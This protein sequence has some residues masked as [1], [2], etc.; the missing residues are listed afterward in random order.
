MPGI[1]LLNAFSGEIKIENETMTLNG[2]FLIHFS[3]STIEIQKQ[4]FHNP[5][6][7]RSHKGIPKILRDITRDQA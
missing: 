7:V 6:C 2:T 5:R 1:L 3:K 4:K